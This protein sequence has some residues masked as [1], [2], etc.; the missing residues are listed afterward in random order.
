ME[1]GPTEP[2]T[3]RRTFLLSSGGARGG[4]YRVTFG[5]GPIATEN[6][7][8]CQALV[9]CMLRPLHET[10][11]GP[12]KVRRTCR[13][14]EAKPEHSEGPGGAQVLS[15]PRRSGTGTGRRHRA[16]NRGMWPW[17]MKRSSR[18][19]SAGPKRNGGAQRLIR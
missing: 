4:Y 13:A 12:A 7:V 16:T 6:P 5:T 1:Q 10:L 19:S 17:R 2:H 8:L 14:K 15:I 3:G 11:H 9:A 18:S